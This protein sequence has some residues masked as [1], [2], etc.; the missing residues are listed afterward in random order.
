MDGTG[1]DQ[2][3]LPDLGVADPPRDLELHLALQHEDKF[4]GR[5]GE[6]LP[7]LSGFVDPEVAPEATFSP[8]SLDLF[9]INACHLC[10]PSSLNELSSRDEK[11]AGSGVV[12]ET[13]P[14]WLS[15][16]LSL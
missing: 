12:P 4:I 10:C 9:A 14:P 16:S 3:F 13:K 2:E 7:S 11:Q 1:R 5:M 15:V 8:I 6:I